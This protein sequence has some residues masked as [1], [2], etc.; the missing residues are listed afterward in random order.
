M[1]NFKYY[2]IFKNIPTVPLHAGVFSSQ[3]KTVTES[4]FILILQSKE[5]TRTKE[6]SAGNVMDW[7]RKRVEFLYIIIGVVKMSKLQKFA[8]TSTIKRHRN[9][10]WRENNPPPLPPSLRSFSLYFIWTPR[11]KLKKIFR[12]NLQKPPSLLSS[13]CPF[14]PSFRVCVNFLFDES[15]LE[16]G[17]AAFGILNRNAIVRIR[18]YN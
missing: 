16:Y 1:C 8:V 6:G 14:S 9:E 10:F 15:F 3:P 7:I 2:I 5:N 4:S 12:S 18:G 13:V 11:R 17:S